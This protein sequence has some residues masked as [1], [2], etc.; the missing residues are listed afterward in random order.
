VTNG[1]VLSIHLGDADVRAIVT[2][3]VERG[4]AVSVAVETLS[5]EDGWAEQRP[6]DWWDALREAA[7][8]LARDVPPAGVAALR[9]SAA[10]HASVFLDGERDL[11]R[12]A[13]L[14]RD[15][16]AR[17]EAAEIERTLGRS[18]DGP[19]AA[20]LLWMRRHQAIAFKRVRT[21][22]SPKGYLLFRLTGV[23]ACDAADAI[24]TGLFDAD[25][26][27]WSVEA[28]DALEISAGILPP[29]RDAGEPLP[30]LPAAAAHLGL[31]PGLPV[32]G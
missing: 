1:F 18:L 19:L 17:E 27:R 6:G 29:P 16:R 7:A 25:A 5:S 24:A 10:I 12:P 31:H 3:G 15:E 32:T 20:H 22:L 2:N 28:C 11:I 30:L 26:G 23:I 13:I 14:A 4:A 9:L 21:V 8:A